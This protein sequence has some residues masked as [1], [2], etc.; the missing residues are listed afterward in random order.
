MVNSQKHVSE[1]DPP[2]PLFVGIDV[3]G[4]SIKIGLVSDDGHPLGCH[5]IPTHTETPAEDAAQRMGAALR[6]VLEE[7]APPAGQ[8]ARVGLATPG[9]IDTENGVLVQPGNLPNWWG[10]P[11]RQR[12]SHHCGLPVTFAN[13][14]NAAAYG[15]Y[16]QGAGREYR[17]M[18][19][20]TL[21]TG[22]GGGIIIDHK[23]IEGSHGCGSEC[24]HVLIDLRED[25]RR[26]SLGKSG[27]L[28]AHCSAYAV[29]A[30]TE[31]A[32]AAGEE[33]SLQGHEGRISPLVV[34]QEAEQGDR[35]ARQII[36]ETARYLGIGIVNVIHTIDPDG[37]ILGGAMTF[38]GAGHPL[39][40]EF[41]A[42][43]RAEARRRIFRTLRDKVEIEFAA[44][45]G[46]AGFIGAAGLARLEH[47]RLS[48][49]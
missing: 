39:G 14:A 25:A 17:S 7:L 26:D 21:G 3:G 10:F 41:L 23:I 47:Q 44:L 9:P 38:G 20:L 16:W 2:V 34:A 33:S 31:E 45:G 13:D 29:T 43:V 5:S 40:E 35:L 49:S 12:V 36:L 24:G 15:E 4:T 18:V 46:D 19:L 48:D 30:R 8:V 37:V 28:E 32:L 1:T 42:E 11:I 27:S 22:I 6:S